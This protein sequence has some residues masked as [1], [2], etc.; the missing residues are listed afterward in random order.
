MWAKSKQAVELYSLLVSVL[1]LL[2]HLSSGRSS[3]VDAKEVRFI[4]F[5]TGEPNQPYKFC[6]ERRRAWEK[7]RSDNESKQGQ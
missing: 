1:C 6:I 5:G 2:A 3:V 4:F 7:E